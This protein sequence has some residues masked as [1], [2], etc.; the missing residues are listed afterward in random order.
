MSVSNFKAIISDFKKNGKKMEFKLLVSKEDISAYDLMKAL[1]MVD[2]KIN[3][4]WGDPQIS[5]NFEDE[6]DSPRRLTFV[7]DR[8]GVVTKVDEKDDDSTEEIEVEEAGE[9]NESSVDGE[10]ESENEDQTDEAS[11]EVV[12]SSEATEESSEET[13]DKSYEDETE[14][15]KREDSAMEIDKEQIES[16]ILSGQAP[17]F[18][19]IP[20]DFPTLLKRKHEGET[21]IQIATSIGDPSSK[22]AGAWSKYKKLITEHMEKSNGDGKGAA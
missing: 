15:E 13:G 17:T 21:W 22:L 20:Y 4:H 7:A 2:K 12:D 1:D 11:V 5:F 19:E 18:E 8:S 10:E 6:M 9:E 14:S 3:V 16:F